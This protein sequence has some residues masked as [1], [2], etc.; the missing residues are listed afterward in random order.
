MIKPF[1]STW[2]N[3][4]EVIKDN[5]SIAHS[6]SILTTNHTWD[7]LDKPIKYNLETFKKVVIEKDVWIGC[8]CRILSGVKINNR[9]IVAAGAVV[10]KSA[11]NDS[12]VFGNQ[13]II[14][15]AK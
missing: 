5:V 3:C 13:M 1:E 7:N 12:I 10:N 2:N 8:G 9:S 6:V 4:L 14:K 15:P 11:P